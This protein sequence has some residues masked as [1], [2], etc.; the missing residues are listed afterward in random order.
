MPPPLPWP[1][2]NAAATSLWQPIPVGVGDDGQPITVLLPERN[3][4][5]GGGIGW[6]V[7][8]AVG[9]DNLYPE[10]IFITLAQKSD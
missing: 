10:S 8:S 3:I 4:L 5:L 1:P 9:A 6:A 2:V 7:D